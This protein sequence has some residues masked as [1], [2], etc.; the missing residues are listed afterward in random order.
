MQTRLFVTNLSATATPASVRQLFGSCGEVLDVQFLSERSR[1][2]ST[3]YVTM[4]TPASAALAVGKLHGRLLHDRSLM[5]SLVLGEDNH[6]RAPRKAAVVAPITVTVSQQYRDRHGM[7]YELSCPPGESG[8]AAAHR[9][10]LR[11]LFPTD[12]AQ[13]WR[14]QA[15]AGQSEASTIEGT[16]MTRELA[17]QAVTRAWE[18]DQTGNV[19]AVCWTEV[20][21]ALKAVR[22]I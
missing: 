6:T 3:A 21:A 12:D 16:G 15:H 1:V 17:L 22:A 11:F 14:V 5:V 10:T 20:A 8:A 2:A 9:L 13:P 7:I 18:E 19:P 4:A